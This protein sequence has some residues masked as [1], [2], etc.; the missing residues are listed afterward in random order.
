M[1]A[2]ATNLPAVA[3]AS[4]YY[5]AMMLE[6]EIPDSIEDLCPPRPPWMRFAAC[7]GVS[8]E[9]FFPAR[10]EPSAAAVAF[11]GRCPVRVACLEY[12][13]ADSSLQGVWAGT[14]ERARRRLR[15]RARGAS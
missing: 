1:L 14:S 5:A 12:A 9:T 13:L 15:R 3:V 7:Q 6:G 2:C 8:P 11:C 10:G 4:A